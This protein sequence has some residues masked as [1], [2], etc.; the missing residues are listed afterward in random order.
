ML[1]PDFGGAVLLR[2]SNHRRWGRGALARVRP[3]V[4]LWVERDLTNDGAVTQYSEI[5]CIDVL[6]ILGW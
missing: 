4:H 5:L 1:Q 3:A 2:G 6:Q